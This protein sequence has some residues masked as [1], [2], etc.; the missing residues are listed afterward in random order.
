MY[1]DEINNL[2][3]EIINIGPKNKV[4]ISTAESGNYIYTRVINSLR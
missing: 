4:V 3:K 2:A 1:H